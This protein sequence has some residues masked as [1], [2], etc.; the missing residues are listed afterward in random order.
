VLSTLPQFAAWRR[1]AADCRVPAKLNLEA[2][3]R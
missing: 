2:T 1:I 3:R